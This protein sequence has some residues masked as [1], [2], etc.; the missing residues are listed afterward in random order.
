MIRRTKL[1]ASL[2][3]RKVQLLQIKIYSGSYMIAH[4]LLNLLNE[5][6]KGDKI[7]SLSSLLSFFRNELNKC[8]NTGAGMIDSIYHM[9]LLKNRIFGVKTTLLC[10]L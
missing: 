2:K 6:I 10:H 5:L 4:D 9:T 3:D 7:Q 8:N 1:I